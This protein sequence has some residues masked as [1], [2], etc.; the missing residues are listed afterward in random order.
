MAK[1][2]LT[3]QSPLITEMIQCKTYS[4]DKQKIITAVNGGA[5]AIG[6]QLHVM[7]KEEKTNDKL[8]DLFLTCGDLPIYVTNYRGAENAGKTDDDLADGLLNAVN[9]GATIVDIM[10]DM[11]NPS[12]EEL[13]TDKD[14]IKKQM[15]LIDK[16]HANGGE[17]LISSHIQEYRSPERVLEI[18]LAQQSRGAD[19][20]KIVTGANTQE[21]ELLNLQTCALLKEKLTAKF[22]F[23]SGGKYNYLHRTIGPKLGVC[24]WL[25]F[26]CH[27]ETTYVGPPL[28]EAVLRLKK[29]LKI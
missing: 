22:L 4:Q 19:I 9:L 14:A 17:V 25:C 24:M 12:P 28:L 18:A 11:F 2:F 23:L 29:A 1:S 10:G 7:P 13:T 8:K 21:E 6:L 3:S 26:S 27:D 16:I 15:A 5:T 20:V